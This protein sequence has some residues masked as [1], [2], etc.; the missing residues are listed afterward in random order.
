MRGIK[1]NCPEKASHAPPAERISAAF[2]Q[3]QLRE[4]SDGPRF[5]L[6]LYIRLVG[7]CAGDDIPQCWFEMQWLNSSQLMFTCEA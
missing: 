1:Q 4:M 3:L 2:P 6:T 7:G 5:N